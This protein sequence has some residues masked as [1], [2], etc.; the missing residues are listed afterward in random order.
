MLTVKLRC[1]HG[2]HSVISLACSM[3]LC[4]ALQHFWF[5]VVLVYRD[6]LSI[7]FK[8]RRTRHR[9]KDLLLSSWSDVVVAGVVVVVLDRHRNVIDLLFV[10]VWEP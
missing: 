10:F 1:V 9:L 4:I 5:R 2:V 6:R 3:N 8:T 7:A